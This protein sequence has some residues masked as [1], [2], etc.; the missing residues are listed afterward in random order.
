MYSSVTLRD[1]KNLWFLSPDS[2]K[3]RD[4]LLEILPDSY[5]TELCKNTGPYCISRNSG[6]EE[7]L[8]DHLI[9]SLMRGN[10]Q[11]TSG[12]RM[13]CSKF[14]KDFCRKLDYN[15]AILFLNEGKKS[16]RTVDN[17]LRKIHRLTVQNEGPKNRQHPLFSQ[18][19]IADTDADGSHAS[20]YQKVKV[21]IEALLAHNSEVCIEYA[22]FLLIITAVL[23]YHIAEVAQLYAPETIERVATSVMEVPITQVDGQNH[24]HFTDP[25]YMHEYNVYYYRDGYVTSSLGG[26]SAAKEAGLWIGKLKMEAVNDRS[27]ATLSVTSKINAPLSGERLL[28][29]T[30]HGTPMEAC[31]DDMVYIGMTD[32]NDSFIFLTFAHTE[33]ANAEMYF[34]SGLLVSSAPETKYPV[35][36]KIV[37]T[38]RELTDEEIPYVKGLLRTN[39]KHVVISE[40]QYEQFMKQFADYPWMKDFKKSYAKLFKAHRKVFYSFSEEELRGCATTELDYQDRLR[41]LLAIQS[42][43]SPVDIDLH[44]LVES[45]PPSRTHTI[46]K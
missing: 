7:G 41:V 34:R 32:E 35:V 8:S 2:L 23:Q 11:T 9:T 27:S 43:N 4:F 40:G 39:G 15:E 37:I 38:G 29:R 1:I 16:E 10:R 25:A 28:Q 18:I 12:S 46:M 6:A 36:Q 24:R 14:T 13:G 33:F 44:R 21:A 26:Q 20:T 19:R 17:M 30:F 42:I 45:I 31:K 5:N 22:V 3:N